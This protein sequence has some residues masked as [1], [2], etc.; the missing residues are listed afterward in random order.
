MIALYPH[1]ICNRMDETVMYCK[2]TPTRESP[3]AFRHSVSELYGLRRENNTLQEDP[4]SGL[5]SLCEVYT[6][7]HKHNGGSGFQWCASSNLPIRRRP[8]AYESAMWY[9]S[10]RQAIL[11]IYSNSIPKTTTSLRPEFYGHANT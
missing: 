7:S 6:L 8:G 10:H 5:V 3:P 9:F 4:N 1:F 11:T 2:M